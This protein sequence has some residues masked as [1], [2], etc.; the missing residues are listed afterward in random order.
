M[1]ETQVGSI[2]LELAKQGLCEDRDGWRMTELGYETLVDPTEPKDQVPGPA[3]VELHPG[4]MAS[5]AE[6]SA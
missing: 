1:D 2:L 4:K 6:V 3:F 5:R